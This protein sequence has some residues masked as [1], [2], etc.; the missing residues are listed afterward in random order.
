MM[1]I[2]LMIILRLILVKIYLT[3]SNDY[4]FQ[5]YCECFVLV[6]NLALY[7]ILMDVLSSENKSI[8]L[9]YSKLTLCM[10]AIKYGDSVVV[11]QDKNRFAEVCEHLMEIEKIKLHNIDYR[12]M[13]FDPCLFFCA[14]PFYYVCCY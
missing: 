3:T 13:S 14:P 6:L 9:L 8:F 11:F 10:V 7:F 5:C 2:S 4:V 12:S 1:I